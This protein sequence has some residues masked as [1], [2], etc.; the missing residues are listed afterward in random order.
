MT[1]ESRV[2]RQQ[3]PWDASSLPLEAINRVVKLTS[4]TKVESSRS[5][6]PRGRYLASHLLPAQYCLWETSDMNW[7]NPTDDLIKDKYLYCQNNFLIKR[8]SLSTI[9]FCLSHRANGMNGDLTDRIRGNC[10]SSTRWNV[11]IKKLMVRFGL[12]PGTQVRKRRSNRLSYVLDQLAI[13]INL[14]PE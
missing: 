9:L 2:A 7:F 5:R 10:C 12:E 6:S 1:S 3:Q 8:D 14:K 4:S 11:L 13:V